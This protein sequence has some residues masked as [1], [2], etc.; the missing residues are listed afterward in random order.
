[1]RIFASDIVY[2]AARMDFSIYDTLLSLPLFQGLSKHDFEEI[3]EKVR[4]DFSAVH[5]DET[6][7]R[8]GEQCFHFV[9][10]LNGRTMSHRATADG[11]FEFSEEIEAPAMIEP[12]SLFGLNPTFKR[13]YSACGDIGILKIEKQYLYSQ[14]YRYSICRMNLLNMLS[15][16]IQNIE[17]GLWELRATTIRE[18]IANI[19]AGLSENGNGRKEV[20]VK[21]DDLAAILGETRL[22]VSRTLNELEKDGK[23]I[24]KRGGFTALSPNLKKDECND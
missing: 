6:F 17:S 20:R 2:S 19:V 7:I 15:G 21:M 16:R 18:R 22:N 3:L 5:A 14:L 1:M 23:I 24:L 4:F 9:F 13:T 11:K 10:L 8:S 12:H